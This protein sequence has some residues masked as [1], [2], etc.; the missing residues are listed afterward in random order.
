MVLSP[1]RWRA[2]NV[3][4]EAVNYLKRFR[5]RIFF[6]DQQA[7][8]AVLAKRWTQI[9]ARWNWSATLDR[10]PGKGSKSARTNHS[11][12]RIVHF[13]GN[14]KPWVVREQWSLD[15]AYYEVLD[16]TAWRGWRPARTLTRSMLAWY[17]SSAIRRLSY[18]AE[19]LGMHALWRLRQR[20]A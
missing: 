8:N 9:D 13:N 4:S 1:A 5:K 16:K 17:G 3:A 20:N 7:L 11:V 14:L 12:A 6:W 10:I 2:A 15:A 18:P 19:Q